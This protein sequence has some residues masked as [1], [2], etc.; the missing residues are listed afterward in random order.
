MLFELSAWRKYYYR[1]A[2]KPNFRVAVIRIDVGFSIAAA[3]DLL[4]A[5]YPSRKELAGSAMPLVHTHRYYEKTD[6]TN[7][8]WKL[9]HK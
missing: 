6:S 5:R 9:S 2:T 1:F 8:Y 3:S 4:K 7:R